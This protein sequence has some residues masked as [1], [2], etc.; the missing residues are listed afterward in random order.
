MG[1]LKNLLVWCLTI[2]SECYWMV[3]PFSSPSSSGFSQGILLCSQW[4]PLHS[5]V[6][7]KDVPNST[8][9]LVSELIHV[10]DAHNTLDHKTAWVN[11][12]HYFLP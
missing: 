11:P 10:V 4:L 8:L 6:S 1:I 2:Y 9:N 12:M 5:M 3:Q 7:P